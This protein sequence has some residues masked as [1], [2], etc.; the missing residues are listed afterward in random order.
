MDSSLLDILQRYWGYPAFR[1]MQE[2]IMRSV[3]SGKDTLALMP[4]G[5][6]K[7]LCYQVPAMAQPGLCLVISPLIALMKD[8]VETLR[9]KK[10]TAYAIYS[11]MSWQEVN[12]TLQTVAE[13][14]CKFLYVSPERLETKLF[15]EYL[16]AMNVTLLA[17]DE[18][19]C[20]SQW[21][22]DF[23]PS[24]L[25]IAA[26]REELPKVPLLA[27]TASATTEVQEDICKRLAFGE[28]EIFRQS[29]ARPNLSYSAF[30]THSRINKMVEILENV[31][32]TALVYC[33]T[34]RRTREISELL[35]GRNIQAD[36]YHAGLSQ[37]ARSTKQEAW[38][39]NA[40]RVM[41]CTNAFGMGID[42][43]DVRVVI[44][45][46]VPDCLE[47]YYQEAG[48]AG[49][50]TQRAYAVLLYDQDELNELK[51]MPAVR[52]PSMEDIRSIYQGIVNY[53]QL[54]VGGGEG[55]YYDFDINDF[56]RKFNPDPAVAL[57]SL[58]ALE[59]DGWL[60]FNDQ[61]F[62][63]P[64]LQFNTTKAV[65]YEFENSNPELE[66]LIKALLRAYEGIFD[67]MVAINE[68]NIARL[69]R[70][71]VKEVEQGLR[72]LHLY[73]IVDYEPRKETPQLMLL[74]GRI[75]V[76]ELT[77]DMEAY[78]KRK[79][80]F[81]K[82]VNDMVAFTLEQ[83]DCRSTII[84]RYFG[85]KDIHDCGICDNCLRKKATDLSKEE[86]NSIHQQIRTQ[87][88]NNSLLQQELQAALP[89]IRKEKISTVLDFL[90][91]ENRI[92]VDAE[93]R[94]S[95]L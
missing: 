63:P 5:G 6:G 80:L 7:S 55:Q 89:L 65:L 40:T 38:L 47:N 30:A 42:K 33:K 79:A 68:K 4:T 75:R 39:K 61:F 73:R 52:F 35:N 17:V 12:R 88:L 90:Q 44:H 62:R 34:R 20:I 2:D 22:Y 14:N 83:K 31:K 51:E 11:G 94:I 77:I 43:P 76:E 28:H 8:Q 54:P 13:S 58:R 32:G 16:P 69:L 95:W 82:R 67:R 15:R 74:R 85:D 91:G 50:D 59:S 93:G 27:L 37:D 23:R 18:A 49:R 86:F 3:S 48:R 78:E 46:D 81:T 29:F 41:V 84:G 21:G 26:L 36:Y 45:A 9:R 53:L 57:N 71:D 60:T 25:R 19:H 70:A 64:M 87:L 56:I 10:I 72:Q 24:Y 92:R 1:P 66:P